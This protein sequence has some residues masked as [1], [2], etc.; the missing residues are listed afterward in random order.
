MQRSVMSFHN[1]FMMRVLRAIRAI[2]LIMFR[3]PKR[4]MMIMVILLALSIPL[5][6]GVGVITREVNAYM[7]SISKATGFVLKDVYVSGQEH[8][9]TEDIL[10]AIPSEIGDSLW[11]VPIWEIKKAL[12]SLPWVDRAS[13]QR[14]IPS[15]IIIHIEEFQ[16]AALW[17]N[18]GALHLINTQGRII[19]T[20]DLSRFSKMII[21]VGEDAPK[22][23]KELFTFLSLNTSIAKRVSSAI[24]VSKRRWNIRLDN[25]IEIKLPEAQPID[26]WRYLLKLHNEKL[27]LNQNNILSIDLRVKEKIYINRNRAYTPPKTST[28][29][30][31]VYG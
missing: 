10:H 30:G 27:L 9:K 11:H 19:D 21:L 1:S 15:T 8:T 28:L 29:H 3:F 25:H 4:T 16:P 18:E 2:V 14:Q 13:V 23:S 22:K 26:A 31:A 17:Q 12:E 6:W 20:V 5:L 24:F 7:I